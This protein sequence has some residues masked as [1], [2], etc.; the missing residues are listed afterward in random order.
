MGQ[1]FRMCSVDREIDLLS[2]LTAKQREVLDLVLLHKSSKEI[3]R[4]LHISHYTVDQRISAARQKFGVNS[5]GELARAYSRLVDL[6]EETAYEFSY[7]EDA[8]NPAHQLPRDQLA[9]PVF[10]LS[11]AGS[12]PIE[13]PWHVQPEQV[14]GLEAFDRKFGILGRI[15]LIPTLAVLMALLALAMTA[16]AMILPVVF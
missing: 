7:V 1:N 12:I 16:I 8:D 15:L 11:D 5:R 2:S 10:M 14:S 4:S 3:A 6:C 13:V 9:E